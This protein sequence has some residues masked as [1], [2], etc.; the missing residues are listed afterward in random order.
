MITALFPDVQVEYQAVP[1]RPFVRLKDSI[2]L[3]GMDRQT[4]TEAQNE[5]PVAVEVEGV[6]DVW[7]ILGRRSP[8]FVSMTE[9]IQHWIFRFNVECYM[10]RKFPTELDYRTWW[11]ALGRNSTFIAWFTSMFTS[12]RSHTNR[13]G[14]GERFGP[15]AANYIA[16]KD[17][18]NEPPKFQRIVTGRWVGELASAK[19]EYFSGV[20]C[21]PVKVINI[22]RGN[23]RD[24]HP[25]DNPEYFDQPLI[26]GRTIVTDKGGPRI[27]LP[28]WRRPYGQFANQAVYPV[29]LANE[30]AAWIPVSQLVNPSDTE[31]GRKFR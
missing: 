3:Y 27:V 20:P 26:T 14:F 6:P 11:K 4:Y 24:Y 1:A 18:Q 12:D 22:A 25:M 23:F 16:G 29:M 21:L 15:S 7:R 30:D 17:L 10:G 9:E 2:E 19:V 13:R 5:K 8:D 31:P 28:Y